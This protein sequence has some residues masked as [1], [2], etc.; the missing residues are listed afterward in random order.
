MSTHAFEPTSSGLAAIVRA[1][2]RFWFDP[3]RPTSLGLIR[4]FTGLIVLYV[5]LLYSFQLYEF[6]GKDAWLNLDTINAVRREAPVP[7]LVLDFGAPPLPTKPSDRLI[8]HTPFGEVDATPVNPN[9]PQNRELMAYGK[10][11]NSA[12]P[13]MNWAKGTP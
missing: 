5:H 8:I 11:W 13:R 7:H 3:V 10:E 12:D 1:W 4:I 9:D 2:D 6:F